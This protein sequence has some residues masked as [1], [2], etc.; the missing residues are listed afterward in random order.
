MDI[1]IHFDGT[2]N[3]PNRGDIEVLAEGGDSSITNVLRLH[4]CAGGK[5][6]DEPPTR[7]LPKVPGQHS[8]Y[9]SGVGT[10]GN[11]IFR[12]LRQ[13]FAFEKPQEIRDKAIEKVEAI[14]EPEDRLFV[15]GFSRGAAIARKFC[16]V[17][18]ENGLRTRGGDHDPEPIVEF[19][20][21]WDTVASFGT[22]ELREDVLPDTEELLENGTI[23]PIIRNAEHLVALDEM[24]LAFR[25]T[26]MNAEPRVREVWFPGVHSDIGGGFRIRGLS[27][28]TLEYML[29]RTRELGLSF[30][31]FD[32]KPEVFSGVDQNGDAVNIGREELA[33]RPD[34]LA[35]LHQQDRGALA[36]RLTLAP[37]QVFVQ[38]DDEPSQDLPVIH[39][40][41][42]ERVQG[43]ATY[44][45]EPLQ[46]LAYQVLEADGSLRRAEGL[47]A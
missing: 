23:A 22:P 30:I 19:L 27:D 12:R 18:G 26:L 39:H 29:N 2:A 38:R 43:D 4:L 41:V 7:E 25:P 33:I 31:D 37:R 36:S 47:S 15:F 20:G 32:E 42:L 35:V 9:L 13:A 14:Y 10:R 11:Q 5:L 21:V 45:P 40:S 28:V 1:L 34:P 8:I 16:A 24:R 6:T 46:D 44:R 3:E 17:I